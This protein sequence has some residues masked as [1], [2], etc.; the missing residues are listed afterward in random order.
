MVPLTA[1]WVTA[2]PEVVR[3]VI[4]T[5]SETQLIGMEQNSGEPVGLPVDRHRRVLLTFRT[6][7]DLWNQR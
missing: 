5:L 6:F 4:G 7:S 2:R 1:F 3:A